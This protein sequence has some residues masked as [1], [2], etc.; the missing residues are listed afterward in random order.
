MNVLVVPVDISTGDD[1][2]AP[3]GGVMAMLAIELERRVAA[4]AIGDLDTRFVEAARRQ[5]PALA[6]LS[7]Y[8]QQLK[9]IKGMVPASLASL[10]AAQISDLMNSVLNP[11][12]EVVHMAGMDG[13]KAARLQA[14]INAIR[15]DLREPELSA[16]S[17]ANKLGLTPRYVQMLL[18]EAGLS[19]ATHVRDLR[20]VEARQVLTSRQSDHLR[21]TDIAYLVGFQD[22]S[23]FNREFRKKFGRTPRDMRRA[24]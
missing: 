14:V 23:Y 17:V 9:A 8:C 13:V 12:S 22:L 2:A 21:I 24:A 3:A 20:L 19:F 4:D 16:A 7:A 1:A 6:M 10:F 18:E 15:H 11:A 5:D